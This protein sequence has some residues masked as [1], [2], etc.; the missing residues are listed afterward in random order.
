MNDFAA[1]KA[2]PIT[3]HFDIVRRIETISGEIPY[4]IKRFKEQVSAFRSMDRKLLALKSKT[5]RK[6]SSKIL[7]R[8]D[9]YISE[10][11]SAYRKCKESYASISKALDEIDA[12]YTRLADY[13]NSEGKRKESR[14]A[15]KDGESFDK[16]ARRQLED[17]LERLNAAKELSVAQSIKDEPLSEERQEESRNDAFRPEEIAY[18]GTARPR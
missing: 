17:I 16:T 8:L 5:E 9:A 3:N 2:A 7:D 15:I 14:R 12:L 4:A 10:Y 1:K 18:H 11:Q 6:A 13:Y